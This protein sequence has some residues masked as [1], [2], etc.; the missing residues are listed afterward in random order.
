MKADL[1]VSWPNNCDYPLWR[2]FVRDHRGW[3]NQVFIVFTET[4]QKPNYSDFV[5]QAMAEDEVVF[6]TAPYPKNGD[7]D[8][9]NLAV[10]EAL[11][12]SKSS[13]VWFTE[14]DFYPKDG[15]FASVE[16]SM[17]TAD[18]VVVYDG[19][20]MHP[21]CIFAKRELINTTS[22]NFGIVPNKADHFGIFQKEI[23]AGNAKVYRIHETLYKHYNGLSSNFTLLQN[24]Q[25]PNYK[26]S[27]FVFWIYN[28]LRV[29]VPLDQRFTELV[30]R[31][32][33]ISFVNNA[34]N[35]VITTSPLP[36]RG[37]PLQAK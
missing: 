24:G 30:N 26:M 19:G 21:C 7:E 10:N 8:W 16:S 28:C 14:Q 12:H 5:K 34:D 29:K 35:A 18:A 6:L 11:K 22:L 20:R 9:R 15:F 31:R 4:H 32:L 17:N 13:W 2:Q 25:T 23:E 36:D 1:I 27:E 3:F 33:R 37:D